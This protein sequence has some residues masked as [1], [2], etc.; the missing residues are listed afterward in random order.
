MF[1]PDPTPLAPTVI[2]IRLRGLRRTEDRLFD[3]W[4]VTILPNRPL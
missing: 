2:D 4:G 1:T 3:G